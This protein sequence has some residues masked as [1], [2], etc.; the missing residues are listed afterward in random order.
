MRTGW[1]QFILVTCVL[2]SGCNGNVNFSV[3]ISSEEFRQSVA[4]N[5]KVDLLFVIDDS[6]SMKKVQTKLLNSITPLTASLSQMKLDY[7]IASTTTSMASWVPTAGRLIGEPKFITLDT[8]DFQARLTERMIFGAQASTMEKGLAAVKSVLSPSY[9][10]GEGQHFLRSDALLVILYISNENDQSDELDLAGTDKT[11]VYS[12]F[13][14]QL[15]PTW[16]NGQRSWIFNYIGIISQGEPCTSGDFTGFKEVGTYQIE[17]AQK[18]NGRIESICQPTFASAISNIKARMFE[19]LTDYKLSQ[20]PDVNSI[21]VY[22]NQQLIPMDTTTGW[23]YISEL[24]VVRFHGSSVPK[25]D[26]DIR[27]EF[28]PN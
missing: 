23:S 18:S 1:Q 6:D 25:A 13:L 22:V 9:Q 5:N 28:L 3:P 16:S 27:V 11:K 19:Y 17:M 24:N 2:L 4:Y 12:S 8:P 10:S 21:R 14:D 26:D 20:V 15:K 7:R